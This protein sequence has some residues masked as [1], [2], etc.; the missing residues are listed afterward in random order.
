M[1]LFC[2]PFAGGSEAFYYAWRAYGYNNTEIVPVSLKGRGKRFNEPLYETIEEA[3]NDSFN[4]IKEQL[5]EDYSI[6]GHSMGSLLA[7]ELYYK[8][9]EEGYR[10][11]SHM[12]FSGYRAPNKKSHEG[13]LSALPEKEFIVS[14]AKLGGIPKDVL[15][16]PMFLDFYVPILRSD[17]KMVEEYEFNEK[18][19]KMNCDISVLNGKSDTITAEELAAWENLTEKNYNLYQF[20]GDHFYIM[21]HG[22][23]IVSLINNVLVCEAVDKINV[24]I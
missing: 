18:K 17:F 16:N 9:L 11:P 13:N 24:M 23:T 14:V 10:L 1:K 19:V 12:F 21:E 22:N 3:V 20:E 5:H 2:L 8:I 15:S 7:F 4:N 6:F